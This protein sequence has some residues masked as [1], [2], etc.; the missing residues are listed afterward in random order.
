MNEQS[1]I[2]GGYP[3]AST[4]EGARYIDAAQHVLG[5]TLLLDE[6]R[7]VLVDAQPPEGLSWQG[8]PVWSAAYVTAL[9]TLATARAAERCYAR[10]FEDYTPGTFN[11]RWHDIYVAEP[12]EQLSQ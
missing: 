4:L 3:F 9:R 12:S 2:T 6:I 8:T 11:R 7:P 10:A 5:V 1:G